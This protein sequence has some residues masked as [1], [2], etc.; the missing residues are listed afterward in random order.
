MAKGPGQ[1]VISPS[2][3]ASVWRRERGQGGEVILVHSTVILPIACFSAR[4]NSPLAVSQ[5]FDDRLAAV[6]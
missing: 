4:G 2:P 3:N 1:T 5:F 6:R